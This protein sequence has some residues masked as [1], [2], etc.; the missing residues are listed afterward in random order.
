MVSPDNY[1]GPHPSMITVVPSCHH[2]ISYELSEDNHTDIE[3]DGEGYIVQDAQTR[4][5]GGNAPV[6]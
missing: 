5:K 2:V 6:G 3:G 4:C 1:L